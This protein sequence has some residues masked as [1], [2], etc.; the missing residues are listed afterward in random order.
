MKWFRFARKKKEIEDVIATSKIV[1][2]EKRQ[3]E[4]LR[5]QLF[6]L[7]KRIDVIQQ[8]QKEAESDAG[9]IRE[10][11][12]GISEKVEC[13]LANS[14][15][16]RDSVEKTNALWQKLDTQVLLRGKKVMDISAG[17]VPSNGDLPIK[18]RI[19]AQWLHGLA[20]SQNVPIRSW[21]ISRHIGVAAQIQAMLML[22]E[23]VPERVQ[24]SD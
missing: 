22:M 4:F 6:S 2:M 8:R 23:P 3:N 17:V 9:E 24:Q 12:F 14:K 16:G 11:I 1:A 15:L 5:K 10:L 18:V 20:A 13:I 19:D 7:C 21:Y